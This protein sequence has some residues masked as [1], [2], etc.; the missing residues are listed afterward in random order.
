MN[1]VEKWAV[2]T[3]SRQGVK[4][5]LEI[6]EKLPEKDI[7]IYTMEK[8]ATEDTRLIRGKMGSFLGE[9]M[10]EYGTILCIMATGIVVRSI[11]PYLGHKSEDP[12][13]LV[14]DTEG[15]YVISLLSGH[16][17][18]ANE[19]TLYLAKQMGAEPVITTGTD[20]K[21]SLA[22]DVFAEKIGCTIDDFK[23]AKE[24]TAAI[25]DDVSVA[26]INEEK[27]DLTDVVL[28]TNLILE[29]AETLEKVSKNYGGY[30]VISAQKSYPRMG[31]KPL[32]QI[33]PKKI[34]VGIGCRRGTAGS[35]I[36]GKLMSLLETLG[37]HKKA[38][39]TFATIELKSE[40][41][42]IHEACDYFKADLKIVPDDFVKMVQGKFEGSEF[43]YETTGLYAVS[44][45]CGYVAS[46][47][48]TCLIEKQKCDGIT[49]SIWR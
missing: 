1:T 6:K 34:T 35:K 14:M 12:G 20:V 49:F 13:I 4:K 40:E 18:H 17:G 11:A 42:G 8:Y 37:I 39:K 45:P 21:G 24:V 7:E 23:D 32:V 5:A 3:V 19:N 26:I 2:V 28:P 15:K 9:L 10:A 48:G 38:I 29:D 33:V 31:K 43:V 46:G 41:F 47:F 27:C 36:I 25:L 16:L 22:V 44:E 30:V